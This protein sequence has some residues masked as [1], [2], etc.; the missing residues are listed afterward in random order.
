MKQLWHLANLLLVCR[1]SCL[2]QLLHEIMHF[3]GRITNPFWKEKCCQ[4]RFLLNNTNDPGGIKKVWVDVIFYPLNKNETHF[5]QKLDKPVM[6]L[7]TRVYTV[8]HYAQMFCGSLPNPN[9]KRWGDKR[10]IQFLLLELQLVWKTDKIPGNTVTTFIFRLQILHSPVYFI[11]VCW[12]TSC[13][14]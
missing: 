13:F 11:A 14:L 5:Q 6:S 2:W 10:I 9:T 1:I 8:T 7:Q 4:N 12:Y 3:V